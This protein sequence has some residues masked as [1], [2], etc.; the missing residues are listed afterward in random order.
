MHRAL[1]SRVDWHVL[2]VCS[3]LT[4]PAS[5]C[6]QPIWQAVSFHTINSHDVQK[7]ALCKPG[8]A[9]AFTLR[10]LSGMQLMQGHGL[11]SVRYSS[12]ASSSS[13]SA[14]HTNQAT[15]TRMH[16]CMTTHLW[17]QLQSRKPN[18]ACSQLSS[19][20]MRRHAQAAHTSS[21]GSCSRPLSKSLKAW[22]ISAC[23]RRKAHTFSE[24]LW[25]GL[26][27]D[28]AAS[29]VPARK[30]LPPMQRV[31]GA[32]PHT[33]QLSYSTLPPKHARGVCLLATSTTSL[34]SAPAKI[35]TKA[36][37][38]GKGST[39]VFMTNGPCC[40]TGSPIGRP[41]ASRKRSPSPPALAATWSPGPST[42]ACVQTL[43]H[44]K[45]MGRHV[46][47][48]AQHQRLLAV[49]KRFV[50]E[51]KKRAATW[52]S[53]PR[54]GAYAAITQD[55]VMEKQLKPEL[56]PRWPPHGPSADN[57]SACPADFHK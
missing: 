1:L 14:F 10:H 44:E 55:V 53:G 23:R 52:F 38:L 45:T 8:N 4:P 12:P 33:N 17:L 28:C 16:S 15:A 34:S 40:M 35:M 47:P 19:S 27:D 32:L 11:Y 9:H 41:A 13:T 49:P 26:H 50:N 51:K 5:S 30:L 22:F 42:S 48:G 31:P 2:Q 6:E 25:P 46:S 36:E 56:C 37:E 57:I 54:T 39:C 3:L 21:D 20:T 29:S 24:P 7:K 43:I 18:T